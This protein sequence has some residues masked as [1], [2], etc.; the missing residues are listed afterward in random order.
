[1][2]LAGRATRMAYA[3]VGAN[4]KR[5]AHHAIT[6]Y[7]FASP[8]IIGLIVFTIGPIL[9][10]FYYSLTQFDGL[11]APQYVGLDNYARAFFS[12]DLFWPSVGR[13]FIY[14]LVTVPIGTVGSLL[15]AMLL[16]Q[17]IRGRNTLRTVFFLP[18][19]TPT[20]ASAVL[21]IFLLHPTMGPVN[22]ILGKLGLPQPGWLTERQWALPS[23]MLISLWSSLGSNRMLIF[24]AGLQGVPKEMLEASEIDGAGTWARFRN[25]TLPMISPTM[26]FNLVLGVIEA[27]KVFSIVHVATRGGPS[28]A[29]WFLALHIYMNAF[30][31]YRMGYASALAWV[32][33]L[34]LLVLTYL[35]IKLSDRWVYYESQ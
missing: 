24:L 7:L 1:M 4:T 14:S 23:I 26:L 35:Q 9:M 16:N 3:L 33:T 30:Q 27:L 25:V 11:S 12:D 5:R 6:G 21:W 31:Y 18:H 8:W 22:A 10:T 20:V 34:I 15:F 13:T 2:A 32:F 17:P 29:T 19:L 28:Y